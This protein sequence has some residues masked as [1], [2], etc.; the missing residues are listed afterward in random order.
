MNKKIIV[1]GILVGA[2]ALGGIFATAFAGTSTPQAPANNQAGMHYG[3]RKGNGQSENRTGKQFDMENGEHRGEMVKKL[4]KYLGISE[5]DLKSEIRSGKTLAEIAKENGKSVKDLVN[6]FTSEV[7]EHLS[8]ALKDGR[9]T[10]QRYNE[11]LKNAQQRIEEMIN[12]KMSSGK[13]PFG[14]F[15]IRGENRGKSFFGRMHDGCWHNGEQ[16]PQTP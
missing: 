2:L 16:S 8:E 15:G 10:Q 6:F 9:I 3:M 14:H 13:M 1:V 12:G 4:A 7:K 5:E 11:I